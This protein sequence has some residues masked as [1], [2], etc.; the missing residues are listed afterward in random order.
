MNRKTFLV[1]AAFAAIFFSTQIVR[2]DIIPEPEFE[3]EPPSRWIL[4]SFL[5]G[6]LSFVAVVI[7]CLAT[8]YGLAFRAAA[9]LG[10]KSCSSE[11]EDSES[12]DEP[13]A[14]SFSLALK[15]FVIAAALGLASVLALFCDIGGGK[16]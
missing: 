11:A 2:A 1:V 14:A 9:K 7:G 3:Y 13:G 10:K 5:F 16:I 6:G 12:D 8:I 4:V 15:L